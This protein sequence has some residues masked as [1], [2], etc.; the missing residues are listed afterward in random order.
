MD[1]LVQDA[2]NVK[3][4]S[5]ILGALNTEIKNNALKTIKEALISSSNRI[6]E[7]NNID[8][9][10][11]INSKLDDPLLKRLKFDDKKLSSVLDGIDS[12]ISLEDP[13]GKVL[14]EELLDEELELYKVSCPIGVIGVVFESRPD[15]LVQI[16][17]LCLKSGNAVFLKGGSEA[18]N[19]NEVLA[20]IIY[21]AGLEA[22][23]PNNWLHLLT[24]REDVNSM[25]SLDKYIDL[26]IPRGTNAFVQYIMKNTLIP[27]MGHADGVCSTYVDDCVDIDMALRVLIDSKTQYVS[28]CNATE[29]FLINRALKNDFLPLLKDAMT[30]R[31]VTIY[32]DDEVSNFLGTDKVNDWHHEYLDYKVSIKLV[33]NVDEAIDHINLYGSGHTDA[34][35]TKD[36]ERAEKFMNLVD[37]ASCYWNCSTRFADG[38]RY[39]F[40]AEVGVSTSKLH[41]RGPVG[42]EGLVTYKYKLHGNGHIVDDYEKGITKF[43]HI[44]R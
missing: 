5:I 42:L 23:L 16:A 14:F 37:S 34:I 13:I 41:A 21:N 3:K 39:G 6:F 8:I 31:G 18:I 38:F 2:I 36:K 28:V 7:A 15:A 9:E 25:L 27:V 20:E 40:G 11:A 26:L 4:S 17:T 43:K 19:T 33:S 24:T 12:L 10:N 44:M 29:T 30:S 35:I 22:G 1:S 32:G